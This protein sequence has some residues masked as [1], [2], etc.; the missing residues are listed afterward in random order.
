MKIS[1]LDLIEA[2]KAMTILFG[3]VD[4]LKLNSGQ[5]DR[6]LDAIPGKVAM[7]FMIRALKQDVEVTIKETVA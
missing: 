3:I 2:H 7:D 4:E 5:F 6:K 1:S